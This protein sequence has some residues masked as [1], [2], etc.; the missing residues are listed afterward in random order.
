[1]SQA[2]AV[3]ALLS[4]L[5]LRIRDVL[6]QIYGYEKDRLVWKSLASAFVGDLEDVYHGVDYSTVKNSIVYLVILD[7]PDGGTAE[8]VILDASAHKDIEIIIRKAG[9]PCSRLHADLSVDSPD[10]EIRR[11][12]LT[13]LEGKPQRTWTGGVVEG[14]EINTRKIVKEDLLERRFLEIFGDTAVN[15]SPQTQEIAN[16]LRIL[17]KEKE[18][19]LDDELLTNIVAA[20]VETELFYKSDNIDKIPYVAALLDALKKKTVNFDEEDI[21]KVKKAFKHIHEAF[22]YRRPDYYLFEIFPEVAIKA[23]VKD[24]PTRD[25]DDLRHQMWNTGRCDFLV[26]DSMTRPCFVVEFD[27]EDH[28][29]H[30]Q[31]EKDLARDKV[32]SKAGVPVVR[33]GWDEVEGY[34]SNKRDTIR[35][36]SFQLVISVLFEIHRRG[37]I[38]DE[39]RSQ[40]EEKWERR[41]EG[42]DPREWVLAMGAAESELWEFTDAHDLFGYQRSLEGSVA[43]ELDKIKNIDSEFLYKCEFQESPYKLTCNLP[44]RKNG[45]KKFARTRPRIRFGGTWVN[46]RGIKPIVAGA[47]MLS[48]FTEVRKELEIAAEHG[49]FG[50]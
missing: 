25:T 1:M 27:G 48:M 2:K 10:S 22:F 3:D 42:G 12:V 47:S 26:T 18:G 9:L 44:S 45:P 29:E 6:I 23:I 40:L 28:V 21:R 36:E 16:Y 41:V 49:D 39:K 34:D 13:V 20:V 31:I 37:L 5:D 4:P 8:Q 24:P 33:I 15:L 32:M 14:P 11:A 46:V 7:K 35:A 19:F 38:Y 43:R 50:P 30:R 17:S